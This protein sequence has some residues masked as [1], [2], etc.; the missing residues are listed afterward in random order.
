MIFPL[1]QLL[2]LMDGHEN[3]ETWG[4]NGIL[5][6]IYQS[7]RKEWNMYYPDASARLVAQ[8]NDANVSNKDEIAGQA[9][10]V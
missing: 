2:L 7:Q 6:I 9:V 10:S 8:T 5:Q 1:F 3:L 4:F